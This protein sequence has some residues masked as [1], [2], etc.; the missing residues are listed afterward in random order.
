MSRKVVLKLWKTKKTKVILIFGMTWRSAQY[1][2]QNA[3]SRTQLILK[4]VIKRILCFRY[5]SPFLFCI[6]E[7][8]ALTWVFRN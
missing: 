3:R 4:K 2:L 6:F 7:S 5:L 1:Q 8:P